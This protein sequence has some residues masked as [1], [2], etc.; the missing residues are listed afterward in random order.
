MSSIQREKA[1]VRDRRSIPLIQK[2]LRNEK[3][4]IINLSPLPD[5]SFDPSDKYLLAGIG[6]KNKINEE[7]N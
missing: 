4:K 6:L 7:M 5:E 3:D 1:F 2:H